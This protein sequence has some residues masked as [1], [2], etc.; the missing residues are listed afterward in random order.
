MPG[1][2]KAPRGAFQPVPKSHRQRFLTPE[3][4]QRLIAAIAVEQNRPAANAITLLLT[5]TQHNEVLRAKWE[6]V[7]W[8]KRDPAGAA[9]EVREA[10]NRGP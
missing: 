1:A 4:A 6:Y 9:L 10:E 2:G 8:T 5:G 7:D 3:V